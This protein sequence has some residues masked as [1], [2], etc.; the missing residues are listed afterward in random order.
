VVIIGSERGLCGTFNEDLV[1][2]AEQAAPLHLAAGRKAQLVTLG[3]RVERALRN[4]EYSP[5][6][7][8]RLSATALPSYDLAHSLAVGWLET[9]R[10]RELAAVEVVHNSYRR[11]ARY[12]PQKLR[13]IPPQLP[14]HS[15]QD[16]QW[17]PHVETDAQRLYARSLELALSAKLYG[18]LLQSAAAEHSVRFQL[19]DGAS[20]NAERLI[21]ELG[22]FLQAARQDAITSELQ[23][24][25]VGAGLL[26]LP[27]E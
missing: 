4:A 15:S 5:S 3:S 23:D 11:L 27:S 19:L 26:N 17:P 10:R 25:A 9:Y 22:L 6:S 18:I 1:A 14:L 8:V 20:Q 24:L 21:D 7:A 13:L 2:Y 12:K 16:E